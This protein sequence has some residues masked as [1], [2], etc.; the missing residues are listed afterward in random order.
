MSWLFLCFPFPPDTLSS[1]V[2]A[3]PGRVW[4]SFGILCAPLPGLSRVFPEL[5]ALCPFTAPSSP[6][7]LQNPFPKCC[8]LINVRQKSPIKYG[9]FLFSAASSPLRWEL[10]T[11]ELLS[12]KLFAHELFFPFFFL[13]SPA[14]FPARF[15]SHPFVCPI[16]FFPWL[17]LSKIGTSPR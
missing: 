9:Y 8:H 15:L 6:Q 12:Q 14:S 1:L 13:P 10:F 17:M 7:K 11:R 3:K 5:G 4:M 2:M 16:F